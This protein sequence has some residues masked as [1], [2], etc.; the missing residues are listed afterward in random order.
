VKI[1]GRIICF[2]Q[3]APACVRSE[4]KTHSSMLNLQ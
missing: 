2:S 4:L 3:F 1:L